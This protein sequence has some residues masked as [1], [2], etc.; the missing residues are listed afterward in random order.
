MITLT[1]DFGTSD[2][3]VAQMKGVIAGIAP[4]ARIVD[5]THG[6]PAQDVLAGAIALDSLVDAFPGGTIHVA[7]VDPSVGSRRAAVAVRTERFTLVGP[8]NGLFTLVLDR[9][10]PTAIVQLT[11]PDYHRLPV[12][13]TFHG[14]DV[15]APA[16]AHLA[17]GVPIHQLGVAV[18]TLVNLN[19]PQADE[20]PQGLIAVVLTTDHFGNLTTNLTRSQYDGW[21]VRSGSDGA[22]VYI[23]GRAIGPIMHTFADV[24]PGDPVA[25]FG[26]SGRLEL[27]VRHGSAHCALGDPK[28]IRI[29]LKP[30]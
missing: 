22:N 12:S 21:L 28:G 5:A 18:T 9:H 19:V 30:A 4:D 2:T 1:T 15:F 10:P 6:I 11:H 25:Y 24:E 8:D 27:A 20:T 16:A 13:P 3:Y 7:V 23:K 26:G 14:R 29:V 17:N